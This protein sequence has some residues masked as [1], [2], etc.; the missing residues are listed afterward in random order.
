[1]QNSKIN[2]LVINPELTIETLKRIIE[3]SK[4]QAAEAAR[5]IEA[6]YGDCGACGFSWVEIHGVKGNTRLGRMLKRVVGVGQGYNR[7]FHIWNPSGLL[8]QSVLIKEAGA[9]ACAKYLR[10]FGF[11]AYAVSRLD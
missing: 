4:R 7:A 11:N 10:D 8:V 1:M 3:D 5:V 6:R 9:I 2:N